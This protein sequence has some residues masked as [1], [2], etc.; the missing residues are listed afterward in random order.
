MFNRK[1]KDETVARLQRERRIAYTERRANS[2]RRWL[3]RIASYESKGWDDLVEIEREL[4][5]L[6]FREVTT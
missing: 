5:D 6:E 3:D 1:L 4:F 2:K